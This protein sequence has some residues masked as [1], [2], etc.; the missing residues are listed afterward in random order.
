V[1]RSD[2]EKVFASIRNGLRGKFSR[3]FKRSESSPLRRVPPADFESCYELFRKELDSLGGK[4][5]LA[6]GDEMLEKYIAE[7]TD[8]DTPTFVDEETASR[9]PGLV[10]RIAGRIKIRAGA[11][12][13]RGYDKLAAACFDAAVVSCEACVAE[14]GTVVFAGG[15]R[16]PAAFTTK[17]FVIAERRRLVPTLDEIFMGDLRSHNGSNLFLVT[18]P[19]RTADIEKELVKGVHGP[20]EVHVLFLNQVEGEI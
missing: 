20:R 7:N 9:R 14:T 18:G 8:P 3:E 19:S 2:R 6:S 12:F 17:L 16:L 4:A 13:E 15:M 5:E 1:I 10:S 11:D